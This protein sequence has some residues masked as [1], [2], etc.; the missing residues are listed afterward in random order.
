MRSSRNCHGDDELAAELSHYSNG[1]NNGDNCLHKILH[2]RVKQMTSGIPEVHLDCN[3][4]VRPF[5][6]KLS[7]TTCT[8]GRVAPMK[9]EIIKNLMSGR[10]LGGNAS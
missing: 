8:K 6:D 9:P 1:K 4:A 5:L 3:Q 7:P 2:G 10:E